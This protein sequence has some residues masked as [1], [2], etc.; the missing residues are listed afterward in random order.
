MLRTG[1]LLLLIGALALFPACADNGDGDTSESSDDREA[2]AELTAEE[3]EYA[4]AF[5]LALTN[6]SGLGVQ[7]GD[8]DCL[9]AAMMAELGVEPFEAADV[10]PAD[11][12]P[13]D[14]SSPGELLGD[15]AISEEQA[16]G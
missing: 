11:I 7:S 3:Q 9:A 4:D 16:R 5:A 8:A 6:D 10:T 14:S 13:D 12:D 1:R 2:T 15:G